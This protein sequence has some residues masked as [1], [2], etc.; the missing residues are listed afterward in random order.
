MTIMVMTNTTNTISVL[1]VEDHQVTLDGLA[2]GLARE[3][4]IS[5][6]GCAQDSETGLKLAEELRP[7]I[8]LLDLHLPGTIGPKSMVKEFCRIP[9]IK[10][11]VFS[12]ESR[13]A[14]IQVVMSLGVAGYLLKS[15]DITKVAATIRQ[16]ASG[17]KGI[18]SSHLLENTAKITKSEE[19]VLKLLGH[20]MKYQEIA[21]MRVT[22]PATVRKQCELLQLKL[23]LE[24]REELIAWAVQNGF[25][26]LE[27]GT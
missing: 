19:E 11:I 12:G 1:V 8:V 24:S 16:V 9:Q 2:I 15:E 17:K 22:S 14:F 25:A 5:V 3:T 13:L 21:E 27:N 6:I 4:D 7:D 18:I 26:S 10:I 23:G 20:G